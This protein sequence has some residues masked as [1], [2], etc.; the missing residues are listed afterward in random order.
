[1]IFHA[2]ASALAETVRDR[3]FFQEN[4]FFCFEPDKNYRYFI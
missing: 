3:K 1:M 2:L 4:T